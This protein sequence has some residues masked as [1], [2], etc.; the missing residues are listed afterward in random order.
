[1]KTEKP[2]GQRPGGGGSRLPVPQNPPKPAYRQQYGVI[3]LCDDEPHHQRVFRH[4]KELGY[5]VK[6][7]CT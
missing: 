2:S 5:K 1:M 6:V 4:L 3:V 7:V